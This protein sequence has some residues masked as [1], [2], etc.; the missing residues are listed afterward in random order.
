MNGMFRSLT[1]Y[2][3]RLWFFGALI[4]GAG[5]WMQSTAQS[6]VVLT[7]LTDNDASAVGITL[8]LQFAPQLVLV[9]IT[10]WVADRFELRKLLLVTQVAL[11][12]LAGIAG[13]MLLTGTM[14]LMWMYALAVALGVA[15]AFDNPARQA[16]VSDIVSAENTS[17][18][19]ALNAASFNSARLVGPALAGIMIIAVGTGWVFLIN[20]FSFVVLFV[21][22]LMMRVG[23]LHPRK[24]VARARGM[25]DGFRYVAGRSDLIMVFLL[26]LIVGAVG[27]NFPII[28][29]TMAVEFGQGAD[30]FGL[31]NTFLA[32][33]SLSGALLTARREKARIRVVIWASLL[34]GVAAG[35]SS[36]MPS[37][38]LYAATLV[39]LGFAIVTLLTTAGAVVQTTT[40]PAVRGRVLAL[41]MAIAMGATAI[42]SPIIGGIA[43]QGGP[44]MAIFAGACASLLAFVIAV[45]WLL[46]THR[47]TRK[48]GRRFAWNLDDGPRTD[49][50]FESEV[51]DE[52]IVAALDAQAAAA[53]LE[54]AAADERAAEEARVAETVRLA[55]DALRA[56]EPE[57]VGASAPRVPGGSAD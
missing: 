23:E 31:L 44:R 46:S 43:A 34:Y 18:A 10:G 56:E 2:N 9:P 12:L 4:S 7:E 53:A 55:Q 5:M 50:D 15:T 13:V 35:V 28:A 42:G 8:M 21:L 52:E 49:E 22:I 33:G 6:W 25:V 3:Y 47:I 24:T 37:Y 26:V 48:P 1:S 29:S 17:N 54:R 14:T 19:V 45:I 27:M 41:Y 32:V 11:T 16:F 30:G 36:F 20:A 39:F 40:A 57:R 51:S 38:W